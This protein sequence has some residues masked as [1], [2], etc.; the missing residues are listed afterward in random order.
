MKYIK[1]VVGNFIKRPNRFVAHVDVDGKEEIVH[2]KNTGRCKE[3]LKEGAKVILEEGTNP[4][5]KTKYSIVAVYKDN[6]LINMDSQAPNIVAM[7][8][9]QRGSLEEIGMPDVVKREVT[10]GNSRFDL[11]YEKGAKKGFIEV[12][13][14]TLEKNGVAMFPDAPTQRGTKHVKELVRAT[15]EGFACSVLF[16]VQMKGMESFQPNKETDDSFAKE[17]KY[18]MEQGVQILVYECNVTEDSLEITK[19][20]QKICMD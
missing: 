11:Y 8:A 12:K 10:F 16:V 18:A 4:K 14:V 17:L 6:L 5:R 3:L 19:K 9:L 2:V 7:E 15:K 20:I 1:T 13:G